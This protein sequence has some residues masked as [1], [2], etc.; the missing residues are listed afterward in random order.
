MVVTTLCKEAAPLIRYRTR[1]I[2]RIIPGACTCGSILPRHSRIKGRSDDTI[3]F[4]GS[5]SI[6]RPSIPSCRQFPAWGP[7][8]RFT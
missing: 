6:R 5:T 8:T 3:K 4:R 7:N 1:D 2:T